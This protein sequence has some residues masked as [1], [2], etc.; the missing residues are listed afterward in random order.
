MQ[1][2]KRVILIYSNKTLHRLFMFSYHGAG[3]QERYVQRY[4]LF[5]LRQV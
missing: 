5:N 1:T 2:L 4:M 3:A